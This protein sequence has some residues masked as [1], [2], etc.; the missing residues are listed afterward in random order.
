MQFQSKPY[1][2]RADFG[3][4]SPAQS[5]MTVCQPDLFNAETNTLDG[6]FDTDQAVFVIL[7]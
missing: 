5:Q 3:D 6:K 7:R 1:G 2:T 4:R